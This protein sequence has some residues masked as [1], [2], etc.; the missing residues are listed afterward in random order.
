MG[1]GYN[2]LTLGEKELG[3]CINNYQTNLL[4]NPKLF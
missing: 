2:R 4:L 3:Q 1:Y